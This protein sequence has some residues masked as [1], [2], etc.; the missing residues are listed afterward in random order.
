MSIGLLAIIVLLS[1][2]KLENNFDNGKRVLILG[3]SFWSGATWSLCSGEGGH[4]TPAR[5]GQFRPAEG[6]Q[7]HRFFQLPT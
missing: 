4:F 5:G 7:L 2:K 6:G 1:S 3:W